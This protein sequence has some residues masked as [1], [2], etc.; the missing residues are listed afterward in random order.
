MNA[1]PKRRRRG[2]GGVGGSFGGEGGDAGTSSGRIHTVSPSSATTCRNPDDMWRRALRD[3]LRRE[4]VALARWLVRLVFE[5]A[6]E[7]G[8]RPEARVYEAMH[9]VATLDA[10]L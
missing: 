4:G 9:A 5:R 3:A 6:R 2:S 7:D 8:V 10:A 1:P